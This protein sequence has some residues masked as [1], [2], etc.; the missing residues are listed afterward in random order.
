MKDGYFFLLPKGGGSFKKEGGLNTEI[1]VRIYIQCVLGELCLL[2]FG[3]AIM[4]CSNLTARTA[5]N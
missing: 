4:Y 1:M 3:L 5:S 2:E